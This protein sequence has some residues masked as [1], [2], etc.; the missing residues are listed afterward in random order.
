MLP[1]PPARWIHGMIF[2]IHTGFPP[3][4]PRFI[5]KAKKTVPDYVHLKSEIANGSCFM[6]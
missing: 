1:G 3:Q 4:N 5:L 6:A 2:L